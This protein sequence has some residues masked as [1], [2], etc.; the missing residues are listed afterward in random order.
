[1]NKFKK[2]LFLITLLCIALAFTA[3]SNT[4]E[5]GDMDDNVMATVNGK[6]VLRDEYDDALAYYKSYVEY[7]YGEGAWETEA[8][9]G[10][11][12]KDYYENFVMDTLTYRL[13]LLDA[14]EKEGVVV[15]EEEKQHELENFKTYFGNDEDYNNY[16][17]QTETTEEFLL[18]DLA[19]DIMINNFVMSKIDSLNP[20]DNELKTIFDDKKMNTQVRASH[21]LVDTEDEAIDIIERITNGEDFGEL[22]LELSTDPGT[23]ANGGD[24]DY[25]NYSQMVQ[26]FS[27]AAYALEIGEVSGPVQSEFGYHIIKLTDKVVDEDITVESMKN[28][29]IEYYKT[30]KY[31]DLLEELKSDA[32]IVNN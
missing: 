18:E 9:R 13:L 16:L 2:S 23:A 21:I 3:C 10:L 22:A 5:Q 17:E 30:F 15:T 11:T 25:F 26:T 20:N 4:N 29:L 8:S 24:L 32:V 7:Q 28:Q 31:E 1:M 6:A 27:D 14:A 12:Y 19:K